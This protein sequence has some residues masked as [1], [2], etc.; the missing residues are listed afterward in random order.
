MICQAAT[1]LALNQLAFEGRATLI[2]FKSEVVWRRPVDVV[3]L[4]A[5]VI[6]FQIDRLGKLVVLGYDLVSVL[7]T[8]IGFVVEL[9]NL[10]LSTHEWTCT[11]HKSA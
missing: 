3:A 1:S 4:G 11:S 8:E 9:G 10:F 7:A 2:A 5:D 6:Y